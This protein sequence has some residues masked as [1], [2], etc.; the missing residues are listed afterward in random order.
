M[1]ANFRDAM[2]TSATKH[3]CRWSI[4]LAPL[5]LGVLLITITGCVT[6]A[7]KIE[8]VRAINKDFQQEYEKIISEQGTRV[9][10]AS[11]A[12]AFAAMESAL[13]KLGMTIEAQDSSGGY[14][15]ASAPAPTPLN[16]EEWE[17]VEET[18]RPRMQEIASRTLGF[19]PP[20]KFE[21]AG[22]DIV[23]HVTTLELSRGE[24]EVSATMRMRET[25]PPKTG[26]PRREYPPPTAVRMG[27]A[28][29]WSAF[30][31]ELNQ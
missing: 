15:G 2:R 7:K 18:D 6:D 27:V 22:L 17:R 23:I 13:R 10:K 19:R 1:H 24:V 25:A 12:Q 31:A 14:L 20:I 16:R 5:A 30:E 29:F 26:Y 21:P 4:S 11:E 9:F 3:R 8:V 28:K